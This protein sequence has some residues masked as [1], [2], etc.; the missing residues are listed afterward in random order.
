MLQ[1]T[2]SLCALTYS[3]SMKGKH[4]LDGRLTRSLQGCVRPLP[5][6]WG[7]DRLNQGYTLSWTLPDLVCPVL[8]CKNEV[9][10]RSD[11]VAK[12]VASEHWHNPMQDV[13][14]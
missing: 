9:I 7:E 5:R 3:Q 13:T 10:R 12:H 4:T 14:S 2:K 1:G 8:L 6:G 11:T